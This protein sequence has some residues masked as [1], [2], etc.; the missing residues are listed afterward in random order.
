M[1]QQ[2]TKFK[3]NSDYWFD[4]SVSRHKKK[5]V[6]PLSNRP[7]R[8]A[9]RAERA[10]ASPGDWSTYNSAPEYVPE[11]LW[12]RVT[13]EYRAF[14]AHARDWA[15]RMAERA[16]NNAAARRIMR[17][18]DAG[19]SIFREAEGQAAYVPR[20][21][22]EQARFEE[23]GRRYAALLDWRRRNGRNMLTGE[24]LSGMGR[25]DFNEFAWANPF[26]EDGTP[27]LNRRPLHV[28]EGRPFDR[29]QFDPVTKMYKGKLPPGSDPYRNPYGH[30]I[31]GR[32]PNGIDCETGSIFNRQ[33]K[34][35]YGYSRSQYFRDVIL[36]GLT[37]EEAAAHRVEQEEHEAVLYDDAREREWAERQAA[38]WA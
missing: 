8:D 36:E 27:K 28:E 16:A 14:R 17:E 23:E 25:D 4:R 30:N 7:D 9:L 31:D 26:N 32:Y 33:G 20:T 37:P 24:D 38:R 34:T 11:T 18:Q 22:V 6:G 29:K 19:D 15:D 13:R 1:P 10:K 5:P 12:S 3:G 35:E 2:G 21:P